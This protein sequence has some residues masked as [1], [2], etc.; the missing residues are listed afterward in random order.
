MT[1]KGIFF[2]KLTKGPKNEEQRQTHVTQ[3][4]PKKF[5]ISKCPQLNLFV[6]SIVDCKTKSSK[7]PQKKK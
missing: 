5:P 1:N 7:L 6:N 2:K 4:E 3:I